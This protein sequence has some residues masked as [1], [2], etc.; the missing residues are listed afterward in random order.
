MYFLLNSPFYGW[1]DWL[2]RSYPYYIVFSV[3][4]WN[5][6]VYLKLVT[7][8]TISCIGRTVIYLSIIYFQLFWPFTRYMSRSIRLVL[9]VVTYLFS[10]NPLSVWLSSFY[11]MFTIFP[12]CFMLWGLWGLCFYYLEPCMPI[13]FFKGV[14][15]LFTGWCLLRL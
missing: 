5:V 9:L 12:T 4:V 15:L 10:I 1:Y 8:S 6:L 13:F 11:A 7:I 3:E 2:C 14:G